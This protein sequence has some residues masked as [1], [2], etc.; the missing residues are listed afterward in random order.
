MEKSKMKLISISVL[1]LTLIILFSSIT[2]ARPVTDIFGNGLLQINNFFVQGQ[3]NAYATAIDFFF[4]SLLFIA[5]YMMGA[6]Y[7]FKE[8]KRPEQVIVILLG[9]MTAFLLVMGGFSA[10]ILLPYIHWL[11]YLLL[12]ISLWHL[13]K[14]IKNKFWRFLLALLLTLLIIGFFAWLFNLVTPPET[15]TPALGGIENFFKSFADSF[16]GVDFGGY[17]PGIPSY[18]RDALQL[19]S[20]PAPAPTETTTAPAATAPTAAQPKEKGGIFG[21]GY[22]WWWLALILLIAIG[23]LGRKDIIGLFGN[24]KP[25]EPT[26]KPKEE[27]KLEET[28]D[29]LIK[30]ITEA[31]CLKVSSINKIRNIIRT[32]EKEMKNIDFL[33]LYHKKVDDEAF[34]LDREHEAYKN[35][36]K[37][38]QEVSNLLETERDLEKELL[39][40]M[41]KEDELIGKSALPLGNWEREK[42]SGRLIEITSIKTQKE[43]YGKS[44]IWYWYI[45]KLQKHIEN[46]YTARLVQDKSIDPELTISLGIPGF[47]RKLFSLLDESFKI[48]KDENQGLLITIKKQIVR[49]YVWTKEIE[50]IETKIK[51]LTDTKELEKWLKKGWAT[52]WH[53]IKDKQR[54]N[55]KR[56]FVNEKRMFIGTKQEPG[57]L[58]NLF[59][60][61]KELRRIK[62]LLEALKSGKASM[63][64]MQDL[65]IIKEVE[66]NLID[67]TKE[68]KK[69]PGIVLDATHSVRT[70]IKE[71][72]GKFRVA[73]H[74]NRQRVGEIQTINAKH[75]EIRYTFE[76]IG[77]SGPGTYV[78][79]FVC[80]SIAE[81]VYE[82][83]NIKSIRIYIRGTQITAPPAQPSP[84]TPPESEQMDIEGLRP[85]VK[86]L[87]E[88]Q[89]KD[90][91]IGGLRR[92]GNP[93]A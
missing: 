87:S 47:Y 45:K 21:T 26:T 83:K 61:Y 10:T 63:T 56:V 60:Q 33:E 25:E 44:F 79:T 32:K 73:C 81:K 36:M 76:E 58:T 20:V 27:K 40:L 68:A 1:I 12:F 35:L 13:L 54:S 82:R 22:S 92:S 18:V 6:R 59:S 91:D 74:V 48:L 67:V 8:V 11:L 19:P 31:I 29:D 17:V 50:K 15:G 42:F 52:R 30:E 57:L 28:I 49:Y 66:H 46:E 23:I 7:A 51:L 2:Y 75:D 89:K 69:Q 64:Q 62:A 88:S 5:I 84:P 38:Q 4:F 39:E 78:I 80:I 90:M 41:K 77:I 9:L 70:R 34:Y 65:Y 3:Y 24:K 16:K 37:E 43:W 85:E 72:I 93:P 53:D 14:G 86:E 71:G 55:L